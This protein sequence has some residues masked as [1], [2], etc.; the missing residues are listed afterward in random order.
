M[1]KTTIYIIL[2]GLCIAVQMVNAQMASMTHDA[3][4]ALI[5]S[6]F[7]AGLQFV[8]QHLGNVACPPDA[9][10][11]KQDCSLKDS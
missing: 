10:E 5:V 9:K 1:Q 2:Q 11:G 7:T 3:N 6:A 8:V 4:I